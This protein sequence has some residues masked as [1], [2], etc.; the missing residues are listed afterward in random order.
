MAKITPA[1]AERALNQAAAS[2]DRESLKQ[3]IAQQQKIE[4]K[5]APSGP[6]ARFITDIKL[7]LALLKDYVTGNY[8]DIPWRSLAA[9]AGALLY[10]L[11]PLDLVP[12]FLVM[13]GLIDDALVLGT[14]LSLIEHDLYRYRAWRSV[15]TKQA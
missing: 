10:L 7:M 12:D 11:N 8:R 9:I 14:C 4:E 1:Q 6:L 15:T 3:L 5:L 13:L 2:V